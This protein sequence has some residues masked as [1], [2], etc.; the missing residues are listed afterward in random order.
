MALIFSPGV[1]RL[2]T[3]SLTYWNDMRTITIYGGVQPSA[4]TVQADYAFYLNSANY[5]IYSN[6]LVVT[7]IDTNK[8]GANTISLTANNSGTATWAILWNGTAPSAGSRFM[9][10]PV[11]GIAGN[12]VVKLS[13]TTLVS[14]QTYTLSDLSL[15]ISF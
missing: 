11:S 5:L 9:I 14:G 13:S 4:A 10:V 7:E 3:R 6:S 1:L 12:G 2:F 8:L 15:R